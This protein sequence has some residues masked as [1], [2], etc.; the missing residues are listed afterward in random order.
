MC[1]LSLD[2]FLFKSSCCDGTI[3]CRT[4]EGRVQ[5]QRISCPFIFFLQTV[6]SRVAFS[7]WPKLGFLYVVKQLRT[8]E[9]AWLKKQADW[10]ESALH[11][12]AF[13]KSVKKR[14][15]VGNSLG[16][17]Q[18]GL[19][20]VAEGKVSVLTS[21]WVQPPPTSPKGAGDTRDRNPEESHYQ[22]EDSRGLTFSSLI[23]RKEM[24]SLDEEEFNPKV[25]GH[26]LFPFIIS[27][28][29]LSF[30]KESWGSC[31]NLLKN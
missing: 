2:Y 30:G 15:E 16:A 11:S 28:G 10:G 21:C 9:L 14:Q 12:E 19:G 5:S 6:S 24:W 4:S 31:W 13:R 8:P 18:W 20:T 27:T 26:Y 1:S 25:C 7:P 29:S 23:E 22:S 17:Q 3:V